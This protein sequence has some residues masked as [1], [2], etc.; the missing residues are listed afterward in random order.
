MV[1]SSRSR[2]A[3][4]Q[5][6]PVSALLF[7]LGRSSARHPF[8]VIGLWLVAAIAIVALQGAAGGQFDNSFRVPGVESQRAADILKDRFP[9]QRRPV[10]PHRAPRRRRPARRRRPQAD[11][12]PG[13]SAAVDRPRRRRRHRSVRRAVRGAQRRRTDGLRR[14][15]LHGRQAHRH[16]TRTT[17]RRRPTAPAPAAFRPSSPAQL[18]QL[19]QARSRAA[20]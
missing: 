12:R 11:R 4:I 5:E 15:R 1:G 18:A 10:G 17:R 20:S 13:P 2:R 19:A 6:D 7:R 8:R 3:N 16:A 14:R 9:S